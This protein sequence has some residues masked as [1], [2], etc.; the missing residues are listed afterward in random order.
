MVA[1]NSR[2]TP[3]NSRIRSR[4]EKLKSPTLNSGVVRVT[5]QE[6]TDSRPKRISNASDRPMTRALSRC[7]GG[8]LSAKMAMNTRLSMP[9]TISSTTS[10]SNPAQIEGV[11]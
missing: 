8:S 9:N 1:L 6:I 11:H 2:N 3:P 5:I 10:V 4:P 7:L